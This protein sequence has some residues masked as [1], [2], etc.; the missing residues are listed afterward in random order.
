MALPLGAWRVFLFVFDFKGCVF[1]GFLLYSAKFSEY[2]DI[3]NEYDLGYRFDKKL[4]LH[5]VLMPTLRLN[6]RNKKRE[7]I[8]GKGV[9]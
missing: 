2:G 8:P 6:Y 5:F 7:V 9:A 3:H 4:R 1:P